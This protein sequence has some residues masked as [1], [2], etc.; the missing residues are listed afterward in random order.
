VGQVSPA[1]IHALYQTYLFNFDNAYSATP[2]WYTKVATVIPS[3]GEENVYPSMEPLPGLR[4][5]VGDRI[6]HGIAARSYTLRNRKFELSAE[7]D[8]DKVEDNQA[9]MFSN[10]VIPQMGE[11]SAK[12]P[13][14]QIRDAMQNGDSSSNVRYQAWDGLTFFNDAHPVSLDNSS[15]GTYDNLRA[16][17]ALTG[18][19]VV[20]IR[21]AMAAIKKPDGRPGGVRL[22]DIFVPPALMHTA[23]Q[24]ANAEFT[25][26]TAAFGVNAANVAATN[27]L[28]GTFNY[29]VI[30]EL[31]GED[32]T[33]YPMDLSK[34]MKPFIWQSRMAPRLTQLTADKDP[35]VFREDKLQY[36]V[37]ARGAAGYYMPFLCFQCT[38]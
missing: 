6:Y 26:P 25:A 2:V 5:W 32:T 16:S 33:W 35:N 13:D 23:A 18:P 20:A 8:V 15:L 27:V 17:T 1:S 34:R 31:A 36:G 28:K 11:Q 19:N 29:H 9:G 12:W 38:A 37:K 4:E 24:L 7:L 14:D 30:D 3:S 10:F 22:T 21:T